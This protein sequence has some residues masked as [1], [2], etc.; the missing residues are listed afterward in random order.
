MQ[1]IKFVKILQKVIVLFS[2]SV[3][4]CACG[5]KSPAEVERIN[6]KKSELAV[7]RAQV[8]VSEG[9][10]QNAIS[11]LENAYQECGARTNICE[12]LAN[13]FVANGQTASAGVFYEQAFDCDNS[14]S[15]LLIFAANAYEQTN[16]LDAAISAY[17]KLLKKNPNDTTAI[18]SLAKIYE[19]QG[20]FDKALNAYLDAIKIEKR[21]PDTA[22]AAVIGSLFAKLGNMTQAKLW[23]ET[24]LKVTLPENVATRKEIYLSLIDVYL[25]RKDMAN[26]EKTIIALDSIDK[27]IVN[28]K[29]PTLKAKLAEFK[30]RLAEVEA[31]LNAEKRRSEIEKEQE[32]AETEKEKQI[33]K[34]LGNDVVKQPESTQNKTQ[35]K[36]KEDSP[37]PQNQKQP[38]K[39]EKNTKEEPKKA[40][41]DSKQINNSNDS[42]KV[43]ESLAVD[44]VE[45]ERSKAVVE[46]KKIEEDE[47]QFYI[48]KTFEAIANKDLKNALVYANKSIEENPRSDE[49]WIAVTKAFM[50]NSMHS[51]AYLA[52]NEAY[53]LNREK[54]E[55]ALLFLQAVQKGKSKDFFLQSAKTIQ[56]DFEHSA[57]VAFY[58]AQAYEAVSNTPQAKQFYKKALELGLSDEKQLETAKNFLKN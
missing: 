48:R 1:A 6:Q 32:L 5:E 46:Q 43:S 51:D 8:M 11:M 45:N 35:E 41:N 21:N 13:A 36:K 30:H 55:N 52:A 42:E 24:A 25:S 4:L 23:L 57:E 53:L 38:N 39:E 54:I 16:S 28:E 22:E 44:V 31:Q 12:A 15:E 47:L 56:A 49:A 40:D 17:E 34:A 27:T 33:Q 26:L 58:L 14:R 10:F 37:E 3:I 7:R 2:V 29:Y 19:K 50:A 20:N 9:N 18:K